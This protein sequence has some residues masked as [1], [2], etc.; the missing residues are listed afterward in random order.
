MLRIE[1]VSSASRPFVVDQIRISGRSFR[2]RRAEYALVFEAPVMT[3][4]IVCAGVDRKIGVH[5]EIQ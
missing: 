2:V 1:E 3:D 4:G 5:S